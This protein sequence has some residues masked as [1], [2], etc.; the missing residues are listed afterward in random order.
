VVGAQAKRGIEDGER[1]G[2]THR[3]GAR[4]VDGGAF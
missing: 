3:R 4:D 1:T 2:E